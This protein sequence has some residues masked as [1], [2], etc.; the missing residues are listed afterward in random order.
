MNTKPISPQKI[1]FSAITFTE[2]KQN[3]KNDGKAGYLNYKGG[4]LRIKTAPMITPFGISV[5]NEKEMATARE[6]GVP[7]DE[8][9]KRKKFGLSVSL[10]PSPLNTDEDGDK[11][12]EAL[13]KMVD[14]I[15]DMILKHAFEKRFVPTTTSIE[16]YKAVHKRG[17]KFAL[18]KNGDPKPYPP[19]FRTTVPRDYLTKE[20]RTKVFEKNKTLTPINIDNVTDV[21][22]RGTL[23]RLVIECKGLYQVG[24]QF[25]ITWNLTQV[26]VI[27]RLAPGDECE[28]DDEFDDGEPCDVGNGQGGEITTEKINTV[29][30]DEDEVEVKDSD[31]EG[32]GENGSGDDDEEDEEPLSSLLQSKKEPEEKDEDSGDEEENIVPTPAPVAV[33]PPPPPAPAPITKSRAKASTTKAK[34]NKLLSEL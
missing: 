13:R 21:V 23:L 9:N 27:T 4:R 25:G 6:A 3:E 10:S 5:V 11:D 16:G 20:F 33:V 7:A 15:D 17:V 18:E 31:E 19:T 26:Q 34:V 32:E 12:V 2:M 29:V 24:S 28:F 14:T 22:P 30:N 1:D 8:I